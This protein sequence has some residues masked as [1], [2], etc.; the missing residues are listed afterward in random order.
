MVKWGGTFRSDGFNPDDWKTF[1]QCTDEKCG[2]VFDIGKYDKKLEDK[3]CPL[4]GRPAKCW[5][6]HKDNLPKPRVIN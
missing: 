4:C 3:P 1:R 5:V 2:N 6:A